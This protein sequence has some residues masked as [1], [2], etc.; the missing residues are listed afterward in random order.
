LAGQQNGHAEPA[1]KDQAV[2]EV[3]IGQ[4]NCSGTGFTAPWP[5]PGNSE[6]P[7]V[8]DSFPAEEGS[9]GVDRLSC[10]EDP[11]GLAT[12]PWPGP[13]DSEGPASV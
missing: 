5:G 1:R 4:R 6:G 7:V 13:G 12:A 8:A 10:P 9:M 11:V 3:R 2:S